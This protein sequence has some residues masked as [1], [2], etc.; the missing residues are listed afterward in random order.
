M[1]RDYRL[2]L[3]VIRDACKKIV[4]YTTDFTFSDFAD[5]EKTYDAVT[6]NLEIIGEAAKHT[7]IEVQE[8]YPKIEWR[9]IAGLRDIITHEYFGL[10]NDILW[11]IIQTEVPKL[12][13]EIEQ[14]L[15]QDNDQNK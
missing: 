12:L 7:P 8:R 3:E 2:Y 5:D 15:V 13:V 10:D 1:S 9:Q 4:Y 6:R 14:I 11:D